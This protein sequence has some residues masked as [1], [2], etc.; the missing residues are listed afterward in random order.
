M[1]RSNNSIARTRG[2]I[3]HRTSVKRIGSR[4]GAKTSFTTLGMRAWWLHAW[5][6]VWPCYTS[7][8]QQRTAVDPYTHT[9]CSAYSG[10]WDNSQPQSF[11]VKNFSVN[12]IT[13]NPVYMIES[14]VNGFL[15][16]GFK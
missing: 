11:Y 4:K 12:D 5:T 16:N 9:L 10:A 1:A 15:A 13:Y 3:S 8:Y 2:A 7:E 6:M 14:S